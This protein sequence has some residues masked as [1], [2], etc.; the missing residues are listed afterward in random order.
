MVTLRELPRGSQFRVFWGF[1]WRAL[2]TS[3]C[4]IVG[5]AIAG[6]IA[7]FLVALLNGVLGFG[8]SR[9]AML[10]DAR[11]LGGV[12]GGCVALVLFWLYVRWIF[13]ATIGGYSLR[14]VSGTKDGI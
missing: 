13:R 12:G 2:V 11:V 9:H 14:L 4:S 5:G 6:G 10:T 7:G 3:V 8:L 1:L